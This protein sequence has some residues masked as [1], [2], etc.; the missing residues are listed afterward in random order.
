MKR[1]SKQNEL[2]ILEIE[3]DVWI[4]ALVLKVHAATVGA[5]LQFT[6]SDMLNTYIS[7]ANSVQILHSILTS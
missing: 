7:T 4:P 5:L 6:N 2:Y 1:V 3:R